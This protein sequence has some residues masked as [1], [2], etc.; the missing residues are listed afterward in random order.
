M[1]HRPTER[2]DAAPGLTEAMAGIGLLVLAATLVSSGCGKTGVTSCQP[3]TTRSCYS[4]T[5]ATKNKGVCKAG[6]ETCGNDHRWGKC[7][8][9]VAPGQEVCNG[10]DDDCDGV[11]DGDSACPYGSTCD[12][13]TGRCNAAGVELPRERPVADGGSPDSGG[14]EGPAETAPDGGTIDQPPIPDNPGT[15]K[16]GEVFIQ[17][18]TFTAGS[19]TNEP[20]RYDDEVQHKVTLT[21]GFYLWKNEVTQGEFQGLMGY[22]PSEFKTCGASCPVET[23]TWNE[24]LAFCNAMSKKAGLP[25]CFDCT[26]SGS[27]VSCKL[28]AAYT[29]NS[30][31]DYYTCKGYR[32]P[33]EAEWE[34]AY[35]AGTSTAF[36]N[37][38]IKELEC[39]KDPNLDRIGWYCA[40]S[41]VTHNDCY[42]LSEWGGPA[43]AATLPVGR[44]APNPW[45]LFDMAGNVYEWCWDWS[46]DY[47][48]G[49]QT[50]PVG[51]ASGTYRAIRGGSWDDDAKHCRAALRDGVEVDGG[52][53]S[54]LGMRPAR[55]GP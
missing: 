9:E 16:T 8:G 12:S 28:K 43:C 51:P 13:S 31:K 29:G 47:P 36:Y 15:P 20:G 23:I 39:G 44:K 14:S 3:G 45:G 5:A 24:A 49:P 11:V 40:N 48:G 22:N 46:V 42:D 7:E 2:R 34:Y 17:A 35:R 19:P 25:E 38:A 52:T 54:I 33:T 1:N 30:G 50:D 4:G 18:G 53:D 37:G 55:T 6:R 26:G 21:R 27:S 32:L 10:K 41:L